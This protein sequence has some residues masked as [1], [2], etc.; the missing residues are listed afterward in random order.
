[1]HRAAVFV[2][3]IAV[4]AACA[5][6]DVLS[7]DGD[8]YTF[9]VDGLVTDGLLH[10]DRAIAEKASALCPSGWRQISEKVEPTGEK[11]PFGTPLYAVE[12]VLRCL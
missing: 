3:F 8:T 2:L 7:K 9:R 1:M 11:N 12:R 10:A 4:L 5:E 6:A